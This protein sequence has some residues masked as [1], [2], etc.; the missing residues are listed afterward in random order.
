[1]FFDIEGD[2]ATSESESNGDPPRRL[3][4]YGDHLLPSFPQQQ[5][6]FGERRRTASIESG[7]HLGGL[8]D[9]VQYPDYPHCPMCRRSMLFAGQLDPST[10]I[11][12]PPVVSGVVYAFFAHYERLQQSI[13]KRRLFRLF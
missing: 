10:D 9:W 7:S 1:M 12:A 8:P 5:V 4:R 3:K 2:G 11:G 13:S 6:V